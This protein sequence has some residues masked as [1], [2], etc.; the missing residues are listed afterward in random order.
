M[1]SYEE[2]LKQYGISENKRICNILLMTLLKNNFISYLQILVQQIISNGYIG[3][4][5]DYKNILMI[6]F[7]HDRTAGTVE[8]RVSL[9]TLVSCGESSPTF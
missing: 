3:V 8:S 7:A 5:C 6:S 1:A 4:S 2:Y 9:I